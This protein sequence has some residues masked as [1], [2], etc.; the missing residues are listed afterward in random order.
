MKQAF[1]LSC[2]ALMCVL[3]TGAFVA[4]QAQNPDPVI[5]QISSSNRDTFAGGISLNGRFVVVE[6][7]GDISTEKTAARNNADG[8]REIFLFDYAQRRIFQITN[9]TSARVNPANPFFPAD[10]PTN[11]SNIRVEVSNNQPVIS[12]NGRWITFSSNASTPGNFNG[13]A[14]SA[15][16]AADGNQEI[17]NYFI[18]QVANPTADLTLGDEQ[19]FT[20]L[21][22]GTFTRI[23]NTPASRTPTPGTA[24]APSFVAF[25]NREVSVNDNASVIAFVS[26]RD[27]TGGNADFNPEV[28]LYNRTSGAIVQLTNTQSPSLTNPIFNS[29]PSLSGQTLPGT[30]VLSFY[31]NANIAVGGASNNADN[32]AEIYLGSF[33][34][35]TATVTRQASRTTTPFVGFTINIYN[36]GR[37]MSRDGNMVAFE[38][39]STDPKTNGTP[40]SNPAIF[41]YD[42]AGDVFRQVGPRAPGSPD[43]QRF[44][45]FTYDNTT[46][47]FASALNFTASGALPT[48][49]ADGLNPQNVVQ[50]FSTPVP[51]ATSS[52]SRLTNTATALSP[53]LQPFPSNTRDRIAFSMEG[54]ELGG[55]NPDLLAEAFYL[56]TRTGTN[57]AAPTVTFLTG[58]SQ[59][60][61]TGANAVAP[62][63]T[64]L[65]PGMLAIVRSS[66]ALAPANPPGGITVSATAASESKR[67]P[68]LPVELNGVTVSVN[69]AAAGLYFVSPG[70]INFVV[71]PGLAATTG[72]ATYPVVIHNGNGSV[73]RSTIT[74]NPVQPDLFTSTNGP[75]GRAVVFLQNT[76]V[77]EPFTVAA[78]GST[79]ISIFLTGVRNAQK[80]QTTVTIGTTVISGAN[81]LC[82]NEPATATTLPCFA[83]DTPGVDQINVRLPASLAGAGDVPVV[84]SVTINNVTYT[85][86]PAATAPNITIN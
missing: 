56:L 74:L 35:T 68:P 58:A 83:T 33:D 41:V 26:T 40:Q 39:Y 19:P 15:A 18:P 5:T 46:L 55:G 48:T 24:T 20:D 53:R 8:N 72:T 31:S 63:V 69:N 29:N 52:F 4:A 62:A 49:P 80:G 12:A 25:D 45:T 51:P 27:L 44:P 3:F 6:S 32:N 42:V 47:V 28:F 75:D 70:Q 22:A 2:V 11:N 57:V 82:N 78:N 16:L 60:P 66:A 37:R 65:A 73:I 54:T 85:S 38:S 84:V 79:V 17:F 21:A 14:N 9:T 23:T 10:A 50:V 77:G 64:G 36:Y 59:R 30:V 61:V 7:R 81:I 86:R 67:R 13:D 71:P 43:V 34:G 76:M 1:R